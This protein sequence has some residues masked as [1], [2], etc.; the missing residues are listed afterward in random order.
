VRPASTLA[1]LV[2]HSEVGVSER[3]RGIEGVV[4]GL[5]AV[6]RRQYD[7]PVPA[8]ALGRIDDIAEMFVQVG[9][10]LVDVAGGQRRP[11]RS[12]ERTVYP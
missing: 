2:G 6:I 5:E 12:V 8:T 3:S 9:H 10:H 11:L 4:L 7:V 1:V